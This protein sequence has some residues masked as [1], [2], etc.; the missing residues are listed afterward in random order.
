MFHIYL[1][2]TGALISSTALASNIGPPPEQLNGQTTA[3]WLESRG[4]SVLDGPRLDQTHVWDSE[5][6][7]VKEVPPPPEPDKI[8][9]GDFVNRLSPAELATVLKAGVD[10]NSGI[11]SEVVTI[12]ADDGA[13]DARRMAELLA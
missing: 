12:L 10:L 4:L 13:I 9:L 11:I 1:V 7:T 6:R 2:E 5:T 3:Q 8:A